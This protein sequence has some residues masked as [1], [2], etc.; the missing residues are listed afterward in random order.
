MRC[1]LVIEADAESRAGRHARL[2]Q[3]GYV[4][5]AAHDEREALHY[6]D[7]H[8]LDLI[9][10]ECLMPLQE[11]LKM[12]H[13]LR[14]RAPTV[15]VIALVDRELLGHIAC[16]RLPHLLGVQQILP[17]PVRHETLLAALEAL[18]AAP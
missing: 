3:A 10:T 4:V 16:V 12:L 7:T 9:V 17:K 15:P 5:L 14:A 6:C 8:H 13:A 1:I 2:A 11:G 18:L